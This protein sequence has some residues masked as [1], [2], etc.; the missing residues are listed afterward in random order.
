MTFLKKLIAVINAIKNN[1]L[2]VLIN[3]MAAEAKML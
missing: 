2:T 3:A 1:R